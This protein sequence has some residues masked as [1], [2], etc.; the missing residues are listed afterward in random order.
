ML[1]L[2]GTSSVAFADTTEV[3]R[4]TSEIGFSGTS[5]L[6]DWAGKVTAQPFT[7]TITYDTLTVVKQIRATVQ[8]EAAQMDTAEPKRD[9]NMHRAM[10]VQKYPLVEA[11]IDTPGSMV[12]VDGKTPTRLPLKLKLLGKTQTVDAVVS[13]WKKTGETASFDLDFELSMKASGI[14]VPSV[15]LVIRVGD[16][17]KVHA[18]VN[19]TQN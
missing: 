4:G 3:W 11:L 16:S 5:T 14:S 6:H 2:L 15:L 13:N 8:V 7:T 19:L 18:T 10:Q 1:P 9:D 17:V 12:I